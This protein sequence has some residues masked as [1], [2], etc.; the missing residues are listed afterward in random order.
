MRMLAAEA[1]VD[2]KADLLMPT[3]MRRAADPSL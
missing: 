3:Y 1:E 2:A